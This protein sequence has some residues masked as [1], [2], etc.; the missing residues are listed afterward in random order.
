VFACACQHNAEMLWLVA[1]LLLCS[2]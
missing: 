2:C 1:R